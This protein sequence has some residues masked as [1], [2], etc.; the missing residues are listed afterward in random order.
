MNSV[1]TWRKVMNAI[2]H[3]ATSD[4]GKLISGYISTRQAGAE[5]LIGTESRRE[6]ERAE[7]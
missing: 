5:T 4:T 2:A 6:T 3:T 7:R 1:V